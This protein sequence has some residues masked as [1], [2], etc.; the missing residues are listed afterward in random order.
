MRFRS[1]WMSYVL[2]CLTRSFV[3][4]NIVRYEREHPDLAIDTVLELRGDAY[5]AADIPPLHTFDAEMVHVKKCLNWKGYNDKFAMMPRKYMVAWMDLLGH[6]YQDTV[7][8]YWNSE[9]MSKMLAAKFGIPVSQHATTFVTTD[10]NW[11]LAPEN[12]SKAGGP[13]HGCFPKNYYSDTCMPH[14]MKAHFNAKLCA[15]N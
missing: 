2:H 13:D 6:Y 15:I 10:Y 8:S 9:I 11:W 3:L 1:S 14:G 4:Q 5:W 7:V 12:A